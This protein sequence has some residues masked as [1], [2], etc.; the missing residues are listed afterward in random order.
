MVIALEILADLLSFIFFY[1]C[2]LKPSALSYSFNKF[3]ARLFVWCLKVLK[4]AHDLDTE[5][6]IQ[7]KSK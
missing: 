1:P 4:Q 5:Q 3:T 6:L 7:K 2:L